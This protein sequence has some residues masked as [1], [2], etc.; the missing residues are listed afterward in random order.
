MRD[1]QR[2]R[3]YAWEEAV[4]GPRDGSVVRFGDAGGMVR[5]IWGEM[6]L[7]YPPA[8]AR[9]TKRGVVAEANR[10]T[11]WLPEETPS[12]CVLH[13]LAHAL[14]MTHDDEG[15]GHGAVFM[16]LYVQLLERYLRMD[17]GALIASAEAAGIRVARGARPVFVDG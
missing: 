12:W 13:E 4:V 11:I 10:L 5:A 2:S 16:G 3:V 1:S 14:S 15:D 8:V 7:K 6:G 9:L 17:A